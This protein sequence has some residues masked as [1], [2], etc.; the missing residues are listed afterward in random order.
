M[1]FDYTLSLVTSKVVPT[2]LYQYP[3]FSGVYYRLYVQYVPVRDE[4][5]AHWSG[6]GSRVRST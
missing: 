1:I 6:D 3:D 2:L 5:N 4:I